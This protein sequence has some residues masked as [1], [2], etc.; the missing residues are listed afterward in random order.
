MLE[1]GVVV[2]DERKC[3]WLDRMGWLVHTT[4]SNSSSGSSGG[5]TS[6]SF[7]F[8]WGNQD[9]SSSFYQQAQNGT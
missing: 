3:R 1:G 5:G 9:I 4:H 7:S 8:L 6:T 2:N